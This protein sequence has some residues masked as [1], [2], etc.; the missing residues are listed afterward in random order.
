MV[1]G[2]NGQ[3]DA[4]FPRLPDGLSRIDAP[5]VNKRLDEL[6]PSPIHVFWHNKE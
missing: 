4:R 2:S 6:V 1:L 5:P 3:P